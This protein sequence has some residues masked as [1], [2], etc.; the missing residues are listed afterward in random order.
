M[1]QFELEPD[2]KK[3]TNDQ[4][5]ADLIHVASQ[6]NSN[7]LTLKEYRKHGKFKSTIFHYRFHG[8]SNALMKAGLKNGH[9]RSK[10]IIDDAGLIADLKKVA[11]ILK[12]NSITQ[13]EYNQHGK[14]HCAT[15]Q[16]RFGSWL[17]AKDLAGLK[18][19][20][21]PSISDEEYFKNMEEVWIK[22]GRQPHF[23]DMKEPISKYS[24]SGYYHNFGGWRIALERF[25]EYVNKEET[26]AV[27]IEPLFTA[28]LSPTREIKESVARRENRNPANEKISKNRNTKSTKIPL[29]EHKTKR[30]VSDRIRYKVMRRDGFKCQIC[31]Q[32]WSQDNILE[33]DHIIPWSKH[34]ETVDNN[35]RTLCSSCN[36]G[37]GNLE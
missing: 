8:W 11:L 37:K 26:S 30:A 21:H 2:I 25:V 36:R 12:T 19:R 28:K 22:L 6:L 10:I 13:D 9:S 23:S 1:N 20:E 3:V 33:I 34:G 4:L 16:A 5:I 14:F 18:R 29:L 35:L 27:A 17:K 32:N 31:G 15:L 7:S 24:G